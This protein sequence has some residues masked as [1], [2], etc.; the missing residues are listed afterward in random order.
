MYMYTY[1]YIYGSWGH[2]YIQCDHR[3][4]LCYVTHVYMYIYNGHIHTH[5]YNDHVYNDDIYDI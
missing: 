3:E 1:T 2:S 4:R 5:M